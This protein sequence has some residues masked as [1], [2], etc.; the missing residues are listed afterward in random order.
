MALSFTVDSFSGLTG[1]SCVSGRISGSFSGSACGFTGSLTNFTG[2]LSGFVSGSYYVTVNRYVHEYKTYIKRS[3]LKFNLDEISSSISNGTISSPVFYLNMKVSEYKESPLDYTLYA[4]PI[5]QSWDMGTGIY[6]SN[7]STNGASWMY[8]LTETTSSTWY[9]GLDLDL[10]ISGTNYLTS[11]STASFI[12][13]GGTWYYSAPPSCSNDP[14]SS[15]CSSVSGARYICSQS[16][17]YS[18]ADV[19]MDITPIC[20]AWICGCIPNEGLIVMTSEEINPNASSNIKFF[21]K[22]TNTIYSPYID[23]K[24]NDVSFD[25]SSLSPITSSLGITVSIKDIKK[26]YKAGSKIK[27]NVFARESN[28]LKRFV[29]VQTSYNTPKYLPTSSFYSLRDYESEQSII[30]FDDYTKL[31]C[32]QYGNYFYLDT[33]GIPMERYYKIIIKSILSDGSIQY[34]DDNNVFKI[35]R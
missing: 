13:G 24:W 19:K 17:S 7:G 11:Q 31:S 6:V 21:S 3:I 1:S 20:R 35:S 9:T 34:F 4:Y 10:N 27:F 28:P 18:D 33:T 8:R 14:S 15:F 16:F 26:E 2:V 12:K 5:S 29:S 32:D 25:S 30:D 23:V 22:E